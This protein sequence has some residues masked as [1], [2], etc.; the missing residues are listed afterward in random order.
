VVQTAALLTLEPIFEADF[1]DCSYGF[2]PE[3]SAHDALEQVRGNLKSGRTEVYD[4]DLKSYFDTIPHEKLMA[5]VRRR[6]ADGSVLRLIRMWMDAPIEERDER[7]RKRRWRSKQGT[8]QG[9]VISPFLA[10]VYLHWFDKVFNGREGPGQWANARIVRYADDF[11]VMAR[12]MSRRIV[13]FIET[14][15]EG[16]FGLGINREKTRCVDLREEGTSLDFLGFTFRYD[17][18]LRGRAHRYWNIEP[19]DK[20]LKRERAVIRDKT[21]PQQ[22]HKPV[23]QLIGELNQH[24]SGWAGYYRYGYPRK[25]LRSMNSYVRERLAG[26]L[27]RRSQRPMRP[28]Q[29]VSYYQHLQRLGL[30]YL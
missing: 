14:T 18:D 27:Q 28:P 5:C 3:R 1:L 21:G 25:A 20:A 29:G 26:H 19:S 8:P 15:L 9:G 7:G 10:N 13:A 11:V 2:R 22:C 23:T 4:A 16:R 30:I 24:L 6:I 12:Y 17:R